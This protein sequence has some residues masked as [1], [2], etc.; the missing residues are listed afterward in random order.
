MG[1]GAPEWPFQLTMRAR[2][3]YR[4]SSVVASLMVV[5][6]L[7]LAFHV[8]R[9]SRTAVQHN[10]RIIEQKPLEFPT[11]FPAFSVSSVPGFPSS[12]AGSTPSNLAPPEIKAP[13]VVASYN[14][15]FFVDGGRVGCF[16]NGRYC[17]VGDRTA[18]GIIR[19]IFP[20]RIFFDDGSYIQNTHI[21]KGYSYEFDG[22]R[23]AASP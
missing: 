5:V 23:V 22:S 17:Y 19:D 4:V 1:L 2:V 20:E 15:Q 12:A 13:S 6:N 3:Y 21:G 14:Y 11:N 9:S 18:F 16:L 10:I 8:F 7:V